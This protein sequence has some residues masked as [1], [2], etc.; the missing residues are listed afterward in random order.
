YRYTHTREHACTHIHTHTHTHTH[1]REH[2][3]THTHTHTTYSL[4]P[5]HTVTHTNTHR[6]E[7]HTP[8][9]LSV[10]ECVCVCV[11]LF[12]S[13]QFSTGPLVCLAEQVYVIQYVDAHTLS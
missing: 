2:T 9:V 4:L 11:C 13:G 6:A 12:S 10:C 1:T 5:Q 8:H 3:C 7:P